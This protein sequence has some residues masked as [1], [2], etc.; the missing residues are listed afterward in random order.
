MSGAGTWYAV[1]TMPGAQQPKRE[2]WAEDA[3]K[4]RRGYRIRSAIASEHS[5][6]ELA[7]TDAGFT[8]YMP[9]EFSVVRNRHKKGVYELRRFALF[10]GYIFVEIHDDDWWRLAEVPGIRGVVANCGKP[11]AID[12]WRDLHRL[13]LFEINSR[14]A[15]E[16]KAAS[17]NTAEQRLARETRKVVMRAAKKKLSPGRKVKLI[18]GDKIGREATVQAW[19]DA[20]QV[21]ILLQSLEAAE[22]TV[23]VPYEHLRATG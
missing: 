10:K 23:S 5:A 2:Y 13:R 6:V 21:R 15:A 17:L 18:W 9:A 3:P 19:E 14:A 7:L 12:V 22:E 16:A 4:T 20:G 11:F 8:F 1:R